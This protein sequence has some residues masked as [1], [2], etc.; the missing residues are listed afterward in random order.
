MVVEKVNNKDDQVG[1]FSRQMKNEKCKKASNENS[2]KKEQC[3]RCGMP[4]KSTSVDQQC[5]GIK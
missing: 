1:N 4:L 2:R 3:E 5:R